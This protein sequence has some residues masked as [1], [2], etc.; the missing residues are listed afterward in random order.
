M[1]EQEACQHNHLLALETMQCNY[2]GLVSVMEL[3]AAHMEEQGKGFI[4]CITSVAGDRGRK[5]NYIYGSSKGA[6]S[7]YL[8]GL[9]NRLHKSN[10]LV[11][12]VKCGPVDTRMTREMP[13]LPFIVSPSVVA[14]Q[15]VHAIE[16][17]RDIL[18]APR[19]WCLIMMILRSI[20]EFLFKRL[21]L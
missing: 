3:F 8:Q 12:T 13:D 20:P 7:I 14:R 19:K 9:R 15:I 17:K 18:Y 1:Y 10:V 16:K 4:S 2:V 5:S 6:L 21:S 11:Q